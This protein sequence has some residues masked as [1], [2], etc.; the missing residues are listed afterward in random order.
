MHRSFVL[1]ALIYLG[2]VVAVA[3]SQHLGPM[4]HEG[5]NGVVPFLTLPANDIFVM[6][7]LDGTHSHRCDL[8]SLL[9][10]LVILAHEQQALSWA[11]TRSQVRLSGP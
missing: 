7:A 9:F 8:P 6:G 2:V 10:P 3:T 1:T 5:V 11:S 4:L